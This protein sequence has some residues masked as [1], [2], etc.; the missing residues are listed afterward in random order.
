VYT[1]FGQPVSSLTLTFNDLTLLAC[2]S[3][4]DRFLFASDV[5]VMEH[6]YNGRVDRSRARSGLL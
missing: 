1:N 5:L 2:V 3:A 6:A 4:F